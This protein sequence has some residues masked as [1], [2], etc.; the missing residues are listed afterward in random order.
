MIFESGDLSNIQFYPI[1]R[2]NNETYKYHDNNFSLV[3]KLVAIP[4]ASQSLWFPNTV[5]LGHVYNLSFS[6]NDVTTQAKKTNVKEYFKILKTVLMATVDFIKREAP[7]V[8]ILSGNGKDEEHE[9]EIGSSTKDRLYREIIKA[10]L[11][12]FPQYKMTN[13]LWGDDTWIAVYDSN[14]LSEEEVQAT[15]K[16]ESEEID[17]LSDVLTESER[18]F[19]KRILEVH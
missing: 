12:A 13:K 14:K 6:V 3:V 5:D 18:T 16:L 17:E 7:V 2:V 8:L 9:Y 1:K 4:Y 11:S 19:L 15:D 10:N